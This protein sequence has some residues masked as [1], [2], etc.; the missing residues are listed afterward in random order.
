MRSRRIVTL[1]VVVAVLTVLWFTIPDEP[2]SPD[3]SR[4]T[5]NRTTD[6]ATVSE[7]VAVQGGIAER[8]NAGNESADSDLTADPSEIETPRLT[9]Q[10]MAALARGKALFQA[11]GEALID[12]LVIGGLARSDAETIIQQF[13]QNVASCPE[14]QRPRQADGTLSPC[15]LNAAQRAGLTGSFP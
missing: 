11:E 6:A 4:A 14:D 13:M 10:E 5:P 2:S 7:G 1:G 12:E 9:A 8:S 15:Y 3:S